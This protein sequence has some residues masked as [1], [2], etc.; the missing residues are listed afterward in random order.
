VSDRG[1]E[2]CQLEH[3]TE[4]YA[5]FYFPFRFTILDC[6]SCDVPMLVLGEHRIDVS[7]EEVTYMEQA[8]GMIAERKFSGR[9]R[10]WVFDHHMR[11]I[12]NHYHFHA[13]PVWW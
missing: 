2:L 12:P 7:A 9:F 1:C 5:E 3:Y 11:Q 4:W 10:K 6:D 13:R 8:L